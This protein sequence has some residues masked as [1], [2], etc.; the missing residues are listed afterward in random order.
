MRNLTILLLLISVLMGAC[1]GKQRESSEDLRLEQVHARIKEGNYSAAIELLEKDRLQQ[2]TPRLELTLAS[3]Y[4]GR[5]GIRVQS[6]WEFLA[7]DLLRKGTAPV[8]EAALVKPLGYASFPPKAQK[9]FDDL[10]SNLT[11][12]RNL[13]RRVEKLAYLGPEKRDDVRL[14][15]DVLKD[16]SGKG[17]RLYR[18]VLETIL[19]RSS[20]QD[21]I[22]SS[23][24]WNEQKNAPCSS[25]VLQML[26]GTETSRE[27]LIE[28]AA[29]FSL[30]FPSQEK[31]L[32]EWRDKFVASEDA[33]RRVKAWVDEQRGA[34]CADSF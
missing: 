6:Y 3:A 9:A 18:G 16:T 24:S 12:F 21:A 26:E 34:T 27:L 7:E 30:A 14:A 29:D 8:V 15:I 20:V 11:E 1:E 13:V 4:A 10:N 23:E 33:V 5:A 19:L 31:S 25:A 28:I 22:T 17:A 2:S 32:Q